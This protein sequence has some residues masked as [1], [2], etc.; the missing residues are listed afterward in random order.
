MF[1]EFMECS[2]GSP[3]VIVFI[4]KMFATEKENIVQK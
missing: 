1:Q 4:S 2:P 3:V